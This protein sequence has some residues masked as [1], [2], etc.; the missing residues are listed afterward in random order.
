MK[1]KST[2]TLSPWK[3][4]FLW[5]TCLFFGADIAAGLINKAPEP[6]RR[7][8][9]LINYFK[10]PQHPDLVVL[11]SSVALFNH[12]NSD[13]AMGYTNTAWKMDY[14]AAVYLEKLLDKKTGSKIT[15]ANLA[16]AGG[17]VS[18][19]C[20]IAQKLVEFK[21][22]PKIILYEMVSRD[23]FDASMP[24]LGRT[25]C[26]VSI[27][28]MHPQS[29]NSLLPKPIVAMV[30]NVIGLPIVTALS[31]FL[32]DSNNFKDQES[33]KSSVESVLSEASYS[34]KNRS[35]NKRWLTEKVSMLLH[36]KSSVYESLRQSLEEKKK[37]NPFA[38][39]QDSGTI[40]VD[41][42]PQ[43]RRF[44]NELVYFKRLLDLCQQNGITIIVFDM[45]VGKE[46]GAKVPIELRERYPREIESVCNNYGVT[47]VNCQKVAQFN[48]KDF[49]DFIHLNAKGAVKCTQL[50]ADQI[51]RR[52]LI[53]ATKS[54]AKSR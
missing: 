14:G 10:A 21:K 11:G 39:L 45:P 12:G 28:G 46:Y 52:Q 41:S 17:M 48:Q 4:V 35:A 27:A 26:F 13:E 51:E 53:G 24:E 50:I 6:D 49:T 15:S 54:D 1:S 8:L 9:R 7:I 20:L 16:N 25:P 22:T 33:F 30:D 34:F 37:K 47:Y 36:R 32:S 42:R 5:I 3:A 38:S 18:D 2:K 23:L 40:E 19:D 44:N 31:V 43:V 29:T